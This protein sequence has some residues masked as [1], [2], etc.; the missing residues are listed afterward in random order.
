MSILQ[1]WYCGA[2][3]LC[4]YQKIFGRSESLKLSYYKTVWPRISASSWWSLFSPL[5]WI[6]PVITANRM[7]QFCHVHTLL[8]T[9]INSRVPPSVNG[10]L[11]MVVST[12]GEWCWCGDTLPLGYLIHLSCEG[13]HMVGLPISSNSASNWILWWSKQMFCLDFDRKSYLTHPREWESFCVFLF[14]VRIC[15]F[16]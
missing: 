4:F 11:Q 3:F 2:N 6:V 8:S 1:Y 15:L 10:T 5:S 7:F 16:F 12:G 13:L 9:N 14:L